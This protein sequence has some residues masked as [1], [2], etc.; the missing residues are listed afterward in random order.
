MTSTEK[1]DLAV[2]YRIYPKVSRPALGLGFGEDKLSLSEACL[3]SFK[4]SLG[5]FGLR[6]GQSSTDALLNSR[7]CSASILA[8]PI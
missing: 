2:A 3:K 7:I 8:I 5:S 1:H 4:D 6:F